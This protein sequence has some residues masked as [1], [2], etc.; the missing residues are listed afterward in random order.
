MA[1]TQSQAHPPCHL[2]ALTVVDPATGE[3][4][5]HTPVEAALRVE[6]FGPLVVVRATYRFEPA[7]G[8]ARCRMTF[9]TRVR[10]YAARVCG[11]Q[12]A[13]VS[14]E[15]ETLPAGLIGFLDE[16]AFEL[17]WSDHAVGKP[18]SVEVDWVQVASQ[19]GFGW[20]ARMPVA[21]H[22]A[23][24]AHQAE[25]AAGNGVGWCA[26]GDWL[27][28]EGAMRPFTLFW[29]P[30]RDETRPSLHLYACGDAGLAVLTP[31]RQAGPT[32]PR[33]VRVWLAV[34]KAS[35]ALAQRVAQAIRAGLGEQ[36]AWRLAECGE[37]TGEPVAP[38]AC[39]QTIVITD[40]AGLQLADLLATLPA[41]QVIALG[42]APAEAHLHLDPAAGWSR[43]QA[44]LEAFLAPLES[45][46]ARD[47]VLRSSTGTAL[48][49]F[50]ELGA[51]GLTWRTVAGIKG[52]CE[53]VG[54]DGLVCAQASP[55]LIPNEEAWRAF[56]SLSGGTG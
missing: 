25:E 8:A 50:G 14:G 20:S 26:E 28:A 4:R 36:D 10:V 21:A 41:A 46:C 39:L 34:S 56:E 27:V 31:P 16:D 5:S 32:L 45:V 38:Q 2:P 17:R 6:T 24:Q 53:V 9:P 47:M 15:A 49:A 37:R 30:R 44:S 18:V 23:Y 19:D 33:D 13:L 12:A 55:V 11:D 42:A 1:A 43:N 7:A 40:A 35:Q 54:S 52:P 48:A 3:G 22:M 51:I 29:W